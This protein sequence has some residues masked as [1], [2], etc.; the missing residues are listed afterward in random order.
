MRLFI[1]FE[2]MEGCGK[3]TQLELLK[4]SLIEE[5]LPVTA[6]RE[7]GG[8]EI[9]EKIR[10]ILLTEEGT[11]LFPLTELLLYISCRAQLIEEVIRPALEKGNIVLCDRFSDSTVVYQGFG[12]GLDMNI[13]DVFNKTA[14]SNIVPDLTFILDCPV[15]YGLEKALKRIDTA[16]GESA[17][18][19][20]F[21]MA[22]VSF[23]HKVREGFLKLATTNERF[24]I[25]K[26]DRDK[27]EIHQEIHRMVKTYL[28]KLSAFKC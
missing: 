12:R 28:T 16:K 1:T 8:T 6:T 23:H 2:G 15:E 24:K 25:I 10:S 22:D 19:N 4:A 18:E 9:G 7:P 26:G 5:G 11:K 3:S 14:A 17:K 13:I 20:R 27:L 21:E